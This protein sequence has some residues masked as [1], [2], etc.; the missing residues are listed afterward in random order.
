MKSEFCVAS[1]LLGVCTTKS[2]FIYQVMKGYIKCN[3]CKSEIKVHKLWQQGQNLISW[4]TQCS[5]QNWFRSSPYRVTKACRWSMAVCPSW[6][7]YNMFS[8]SNEITTPS[9]SVSFTRVDY[10][11]WNDLSFGEQYGFWDKYSTQLA[12]S[13]LIDR[14]RSE[15]DYYTFVLPW[16]FQCVSYAWP[17][18]I[19][20]TW[21]L[22]SKSTTLKWFA[23]YLTERL[24]YVYYD[25]LR[26]VT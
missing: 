6:R 7:I 15:I 13:E 25:G 23:S 18:Y 20:K 26:A 9:T 8:C 5:F 17:W 14:L 22:W 3:V 10:F 12:I 24:Q 2:L 19:I 4:Y 1:Q 16:S 21:I 11:I